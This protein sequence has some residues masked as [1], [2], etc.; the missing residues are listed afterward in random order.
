MISGPR[1]IVHQD[2]AWRADHTGAIS[3]EWQKGW[4]FQSLIDAK[5][6]V[7]A[8]CH[9]APCHHRDT[10]DLVKLRDRFGPDAPSRGK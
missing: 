3:A 6:T 7:T 8:H 9:H 5:M 1:W 2:K 10:L 4:T